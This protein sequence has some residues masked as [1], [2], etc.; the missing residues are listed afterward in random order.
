MA[1]HTLCTVT[2]WL[3]KKSN[4]CS[5]VVSH[6]ILFTYTLK[7]PGVGLGL[8]A[9][10]CIGSGLFFFLG[11]GPSV[12]SSLSLL[13]GGSSLLFSFFSLEAGASVVYSP[14]L[15][16]NLCPFKSLIVASNF[17]HS[18]FVCTKKVPY[19]FFFLRH[20]HRLCTV[21]F[22]VLRKSSKSSYVV[23]PLMYP[24]DIKIIPGIASGF[25]FGKTYFSGLSSLSLN[26]N[27]RPFKSVSIA[28]NFS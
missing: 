13:G 28:S 1:N 23:S 25:S 24:T 5:D 2:F 4:N 11:G 16:V 18:S 9:V 21:T 22:K 10:P 27:L 3:R 12:I 6:R 7:K 20:N 8:W 17:S 14:S 19:L 15:N 26:V